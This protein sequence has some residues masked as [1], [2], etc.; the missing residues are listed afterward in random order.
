MK[1]R[2]IIPGWPRGRSTTVAFENERW[3]WP[4]YSFGNM[5]R[6]RDQSYSETESRLRADYEA[7]VEYHRKQ[8][9]M[10]DVYRYYEGALWMRSVV[11]D[12]EKFRRLLM[13]YPFP[14]LQ[15]QV[16]IVRKM[17]QNIE[18]STRAGLTYCGKEGAE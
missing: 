14:L 15:A 1:A 13:S 16:D 3:S 11:S 2:D 6:M 12:E 18:A 8:Q 10:V 9:E 5:W 17:F 7:E 4:W